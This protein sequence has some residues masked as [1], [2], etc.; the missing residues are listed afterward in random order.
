MPIVTIEQYWMGRDKQYPN[1]LT[2]EVVQN[3]KELLA[4]VNL[5]LKEIGV[6]KATV[7]SGWRPAG[8][9]AGVAGAAT[10]SNHIIGKAIDLRDTDG[11]L[12]EKVAANLHVAQRLGLYFE[13]KRYTPTWTHIQSV[14]PKSKKRVYIPSLAAAPAPNAWD[15]KYDAK[16][17]A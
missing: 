6:D 9:N 7:S 3:A 5:F 12:W 10:K 4:K 15:G 2:P 8:L 16:Y 17:D 1:D 14:P 13:D 11:K